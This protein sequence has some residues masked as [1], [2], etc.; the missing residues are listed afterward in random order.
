[1]KT[2]V[3]LLT[4]AIGIAALAAAPLRAAPEKGLLMD[5]TVHTKEQMS[6]V[7]AIPPR[8]LHKKI[9]TRPGEFDPRAFVRAESQASCKIEHYKK[10]GKLVTFDV[11]CSGPQPVTSH[12]EFHLTAD[13]GFTG[14][15]HTSL[16]AA[17]H[18][19]T[20]DSQFTG[21]RAGTCTYK[22]SKASG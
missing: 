19:V 11:T 14:T 13:S 9:C 5:L 17:G 12:G 8:T 16:S 1:M 2:T 6:G 7:P 21:Q 22:P 4:G 20:V 18:A 10:S 3:A 15:M